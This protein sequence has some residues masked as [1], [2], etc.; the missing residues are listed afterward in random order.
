LGRYTEE[1]SSTVTAPL[2]Y[3]ALSTNATT[4]L[5]GVGVS[6]AIAPKAMVFARGDLEFDVNVASGSYSADGIAEL[7]VINFN[8]NPVKNRASGTLGAFYDIGRNQ[9]LNVTGVYREEPFQG[10]STTSLMVN[11]AVGL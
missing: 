3:R 7:S 9:R 2:N 6:F 8:A 1:S 10:K 5:V 11:Y 4:A